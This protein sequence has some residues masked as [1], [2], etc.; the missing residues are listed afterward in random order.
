VRLTQRGYIV[1]WCAFC[2]TMTLLLI[3]V[4]AYV[5]DITPTQQEMESLR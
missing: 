2:V 4:D 1:L 3:F 5:L